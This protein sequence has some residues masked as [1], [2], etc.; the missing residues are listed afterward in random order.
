LAPFPSGKYKHEVVEMRKAA[1]LPSGEGGWDIWH[2]GCVDGESAAEMEA[3]VD[4]VIK[5]VRDAHHSW[6]VNSSEAQGGDILIVSHGHFSRCFL[7]RWLKL[8]LADGQKF[9]LDPGG[10][11]VFLESC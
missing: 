5:A 6:W 4:G 9:I 7:A 11:S 8:P 2:D 3:R 1:G 10:V